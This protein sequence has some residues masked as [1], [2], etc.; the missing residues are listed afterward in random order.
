MTNKK[1][2]TNQGIIFVE[3]IIVALLFFAMI[4]G[5]IFYGVLFHRYSALSDAVTSV[6]RSA[7]VDVNCGSQNA[8]GK[9]PN[10]D[11]RYLDTPDSTYKYIGDQIK[12]FITS[13]GYAKDVSDV[14]IN[15]PSDPSP[16]IELCKDSSGRCRIRASVKWHLSCFFCIFTGG[17][18]ILVQSDSGFED[19]CFITPSAA[20]SSRGCLGV[21]DIC[22]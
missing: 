8:S 2:R 22:S 10:Y 16:G 1:N 21:T 4:D 3:F 20:N 9:Y 14:T 7:S 13:H 5:I 11:H 12:D 17:K 6:L 19:P 18:D 15:P